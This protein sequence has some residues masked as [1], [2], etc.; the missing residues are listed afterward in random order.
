MPQKTRIW[1]G[2]Q[3]RLATGPLISF[4]HASKIKVKRYELFHCSMAKHGWLLACLFIGGAVCIGAGAMLFYS[5]SLTRN[6]DLSG[7]DPWI[8][9]TG[10]A[11]IGIGG[12]LV[13]V[14]IILP[15][16]APRPR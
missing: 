1:E 11:I 7:L 5:K 15:G 16:I 3:R 10:I 6:M 13:G 14:G 2:L 9:L 4:D 8:A 12:L